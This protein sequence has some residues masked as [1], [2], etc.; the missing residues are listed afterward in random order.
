MSIRGK[1]LFPA[2]VLLLFLISAGALFA[3]GQKED[4]LST[5]QQLINDKKYNDAILV[6]TQVMKDTPQDFDRAQALL[7]KIDLA[8][9][10][11]NEK[12]AELIK[13]FNSGDLE[14]AYQIIKEL[15]ALDKAPNART[16][17]SQAY[18][19]QTATFVYDTK[20]FQGV[21]EKALPL[22]QAGN[23]AG[24]VETYVSGFDIGLDIFNQANYGNITV[25][26]IT[27]L[28]SDMKSAANNYVKALGQLDSQA[29]L[30]G[31]DIA[32]P[33]RLG[34]EIQGFVETLSQIEAIKAQINTDM[35]N[36]KA[37]REAII[38]QRSSE[39]DVPLISYLDRIVN[40]RSDASQPEGILVAVS[41]S[42]SKSLDGAYTE[43]SKRAADELASAKASFNAKQWD[44]AL[45]QLA[46]AKSYALMAERT[47]AAW[48]LQVPVGDSLT[49]PAGGWTV[50]NQKLPG[51]LNNQ[52]IAEAADGYVSL[53]T[54][55]RAINDLAATA[56][57]TTGTVAELTAQRQQVSKLSSA[58]RGIQTTWSGLKER[59]T[60]LNNQ[61]ID[62]AEGLK[63]I[64]A[65]ISAADVAIADADRTS[66]VIVAREGTLK[67]APVAPDLA[68]AKASVDQA[69]QLIA[70]IAPKI[71]TA[72]VAADVKEKYPDQAQ[73]LL[74]KVKADLLGYQQ[75]VTGAT[76]YLSGE[77]P[78]VVNA[79]PV[80][81][82]IEESRQLTA[83][84]TSLSS[85]ADSL[86]SQAKQQLFDANRYRQEGENK[87]QL[88][89]NDL[90]QGNFASAR[91][92]IAA[93]ADSFDKSLSYQEDPAVRQVRDQQIP[94]LS[95]QI[96][97]SENAIVVRDV[98]NYIN[99]GR[100][101]YSQGDYARAQDVFLRAEARWRTT[102]TDPNPEVTTWL[103]YVNTAL[104]INSGRAVAPTD[105]LY[106]E[107]TQIL[108][109][110]QTDY[111]EGK[112]LDAQG[113]TAQ[114]NSLLTE[115][116]TKL[117]YVQIPF[118]LNKE[119]RVLSLKILQLTDPKNFATTFKQRFDQAV[120]ELN[121]NPQDAYIALKDLQAI[122]PTFP[123]LAQ[124]L[125]RAEILTGIRRPPPDPTKIT[126][127]NDLYQKAFD[128]VRQNV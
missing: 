13:V 105:P 20:Q 62:L 16:L 107:I 18:A 22:L 42:W 14:Q 119:A 59:Y 92:Q 123:G 49:I 100:D 120:G 88:A 97:D 116:Q 48:G 29:K 104:S 94:Q 1:F 24:A 25:D 57:T 114:A 15:E 43:I 80:Q 31:Q 38:K 95:S 68:L 35:T 90:G 128:I 19:R 23:Y 117:L 106:S 51:A 33:A 47:A 70:G 28:K 41:D 50:I 121:T 115:A 76:G 44:R 85:N 78:A 64:D 124:G 101:F 74:T 122:E 53:I 32:Q 65:V 67:L 98:R 17:E 113:Q 55:S 52:L 6:L 108:N 112:Q 77:S 81:K 84:I 103:Q 126:E 79:Q 39:Q 109:L 89:K 46:G 58:V 63:E 125:Y 34:T 66:I 2:A 96:T 93:A 5:A 110:A 26:K 118:P 86:L 8:R 127:S 61:K 27:N 30:I 111:E 87:L 75:T 99:Q 54:Q 91:Q 72:I 40:G 60:A 10:G 7:A 73:Q 4:P 45:G 9:Q 12:V 21:M 37:E 56:N 82:V 11:Y 69:A 83:Q 3:S 36:L 71:A 102:N